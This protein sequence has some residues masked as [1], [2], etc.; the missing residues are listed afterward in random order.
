MT[1]PFADTSTLDYIAF[2]L[3]RAK[4]HAEGGIPVRWMTMR[5]ELQREYLELAKARYIDWVE[6]ER[7]AQVERSGP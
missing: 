5:H 7:D 1:N 2:Q 4:V 6:S 3:Y